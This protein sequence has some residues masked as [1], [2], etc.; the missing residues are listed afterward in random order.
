MGINGLNS[1][2]ISLYLTFATAFLMGGIFISG[3]AI[4]QRRT[5]RSI[6]KLN[7]EERLYENI[8]L[9][10]EAGKWEATIKSGNEFRLL[11]NK[12]KRESS[13]NLLIAQ[14]SLRLRDIN[15]ALSEVAKL[16]LKFPNSDYIDDT[17]WITAQCALMAE[18][19]EEATQDLRWILGFSSDSILVQNSQ[20][21][22]AELQSFLK[23][24]KETNKRNEYST[25]SI[26]KLA[27]LL[28]FTGQDS[29]SASS[30]H[31]GFQASWSNF[32]EDSV[33]T[34]DTQGDPVQAARI[35]RDLV[36]S[37]SAQVII[38]GLEP[39]EA[40]VLAAAAEADHIPFLTTACGVDGVASISRYAFQGRP[41]F[42]GV[43]A[44]LAR[45]SVSDLGLARFAI[46]A[47]IS[48]EGRQIAAGFKAEVEEAGGE[49]L[50]EEAYYPGTL[51]FK[52]YFARIR[53]IG[54]R[55][56]YDDS[57]R[58]YFYANGYILR[59]SLE[60][61]LL[62]EYLQA[63]AQSIE[64]ELS[65]DE[66]TTWTIADEFLDSLWA[67]D[68]ETLREWIIE[69]EEEIDSLEIPLNV[70]DGLLF[71]IESDQVQMAA[72]QFARANINTQ[73][74]GGEMWGDRTA[75]SQVKRYVNG[76][77]F[78]DPLVSDG[79]KEYYEFAETIAKNGDMIIDRFVMAGERAARMIIFATKGSA[80][81]EDI[82][83]RLSQIR[84]LETLSGKVSLLKEERVD[85]RVRL[86]RY[87]D[88]EFNVIEN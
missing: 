61:F 67:A 55:R 88:G 5:V 6:Y 14:S 78:A 76:I 4:A 74:L 58:N 68:H 42:R 19:W 86:V 34:Y 41:D 33:I 84:D 69:N 2:K 9:D 85:R 37:N 10:Y 44:R 25:T 43:G 23:L 8:R 46:L 56:S 64:F 17:R 77:V 62:P 29:E 66:D 24:M 28:P 63:S 80:S 18:R 3:E 16:R 40:A 26:L 70:F 38:G 39:S 47:P 1:F 20:E 87:S 65:F 51:D 48:Q 13:V 30:F 57:L 82:R 31:A 75:I 83:R 45:H 50:A 35:V 21:R 81:S 73:L 54:L 11:Y 49:I 32:S 22:L 79:G 72:P 59:D 7:P 27:L 15:G 52:D 12:S 60:Y 53:A 71:V 36:A